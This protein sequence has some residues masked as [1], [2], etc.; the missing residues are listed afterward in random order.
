MSNRTQSHPNIKFAI[1]WLEEVGRNKNN[2]NAGEALRGMID[3]LHTFDPKD[4]QKPEW[5]KLDLDL[6][7][8]F[9]A[10]N[11]IRDTDPLVLRT[12][13]DAFDDDYIE[14]Y[15]D[16]WSRLWTLLWRSGKLYD[17]TFEGIDLKALDIED[18]EDVDVF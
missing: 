13:L 17:R 3:F 11:S 12:K 5:D 9:K 6:Y 4:R 10:R 16:L 1:E 8:A 2:G 14:G 18:Q 7:K 15:I